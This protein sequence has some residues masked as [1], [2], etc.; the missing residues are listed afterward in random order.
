[1]P[2]IQGSAGHLQALE[3][4]RELNSGHERFLSGHSAHPHAS[5]ERLE[6]LVAGQHPRAAILSCADSRVPVE[7]LFDAGFGD[8]FVVR[9]AG[10][11]CTQATIGS[12][13][14]GIGHLGIELLVV[15]G[16][17]GCGAVTAAYAE[18]AVFTPQ[19]HDLVHMIRA[20]LDERDPASPAAAPPAAP[21]DLPQAFRRNPVQAARHL[22]RGS[23][24]LQQRLAAGELLLEAAYYT[25]RRGEIE[26][27][28]QVDAE[29]AL[30]PS[31]LVD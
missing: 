15:M 28:G 26:W 11:A 22:V 14:Y 23:A 24:L 13:D 10:N 30:Q 4:L 7:L 8:L 9:N 29:G 12:L 18:H 27:L 20:G 2:D 5:S 1:M 3:V 17:E 19:L 16:H 21:A 25:L 31:C 6:Q